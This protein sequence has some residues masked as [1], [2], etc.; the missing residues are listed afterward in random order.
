M[1]KS[2]LNRILIACAIIPM[3]IVAQTSVDV[4]WTGTPGEMETFIHG[5]IKKAISVYPLFISN[6]FTNSL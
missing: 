3:V 1:Q 5:D 4:P 6:R 2:I